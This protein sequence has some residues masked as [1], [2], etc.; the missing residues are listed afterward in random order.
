MNK[1]FYFKILSLILTMVM[2]FSAL[3]LTSCVMEPTENTPTLC[4][5][6]YSDAACTVAKTCT[7]C[8]ETEGKALGHDYS[9]ATCTTLKTCAR[10]GETDG[11]KLGHDLA[12]ATCITPATCK[13]CGATDEKELGHDYAEATCTAAKTCTRCGDTVGES[14]GHDYV[15]ATYTAPKTCTICG[16]T[17][18]EALV[19]PIPEKYNLAIQLEKLPTVTP[20]M[21]EDEMRDMIVQFMYI[22][23]N[24]AYTPDFGEAN[25][26][27]YYIKN[28][29]G[30]YKGNLNLDNAKITF[31]EGSYYGGIPYVG[32]AAGSLYR[33]LEFYDADS[34][35]MNWD[36][37]I[38]TNRE[39]MESGDV[40]YPDLG[41][42]YFGNSCS[43]A[44]V[45]SW[46]RVSNSIKSF[47]TN[48]W[49]PANGYVLVGDYKLNN[50]GTTGSDTTEICEANG[51]EVMFESY[52]KLKR[53]DGLLVTGH[54]VMC[55]SDAEVVRDENGNI[56]GEKSY[57]LFAEQDCCFLTASPV[58]GGV[59]RYAP[60]NDQGD[61]YRMSGNFAG[62]MDS[63]KIKECKHTFEQ[64]YERGK[65]P[66][67]IPEL[68]GEAPVESTTV[69]LSDANGVYSASTIKA[70]EMNSMTIGSNYAISDIHFIIRDEDGNEL[71]NAMYAKYAEKIQELMTY[72]VNSA[73]FN[74]E[75]Y[76][77]NECINSAILEHAASG[78]NT[79]EITARVSTGEL[80]TVYKGTLA[81]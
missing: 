15:D 37:I 65:L 48:G 57:I 63:G 7:R 12:P 46:L 73:L 44:C 1:P 61:V 36:P 10:C 32:N 75:I 80:L 62:N 14:L 4:T 11:D 13:R 34:G 74:N 41:S 60:L 69:E 51:K 18:G 76:E 79:L 59:D 39:N 30:P 25:E 40:L 52:A 23:L 53:A 54:A 3:P 78:N 33:W 50:K 16:A 45:W 38:R 2:I 9:N 31:K 42:A 21:T 58:N 20:D 56:D 24:F 17:E 5:H 47:W 35:V 27:G 64:L 77:D 6:D 72:N 70:S 66:F 28:L 71:F 43:S 22:Q 8:G 67:T 81:E 19:S 68:C 26:Y 55:V 49:K 29:Y